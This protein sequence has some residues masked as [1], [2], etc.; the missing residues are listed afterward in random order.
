MKPKFRAS[1][2]ISAAACL[3]PCIAFAQNTGA[4]SATPSANSGGIETVVVT[5][6]KREQK[7]NDVPMSITAAGA[8]E[9]RDRG[10]TNTSDLVKIVPGFTVTQTNSLAPVYTLRGVGLYLYDAGL[11]AAPAVSV[12]SDEVALPSPLMTEAATLDL[13]HVEVLKGPQGTLFGQN[14]TGGAINYVAAKPTD[15][16]MAGADTTVARFGKVEADGFVS[17]PLSDTLDGRLAV[18]TTQGGA[19]QESATR[20]GDMLGNARQFQGRLLLDWHPSDQ[21]KFVLNVTGATDN[22]DTLAGQ[23]YAA[24]P[25]IPAAAPPGL[26]TSPIV[27]HDPQSADWSPGFPDRSHD[28]YFRTTLRGDYELTSDITLTSLTSYQ[29]LHTDRMLDQDGSAAVLLQLEPNGEAKQFDQELRLSGTTQTLNWIV[30][31][32]YGHSDITDNLFYNPYH[33]TGSY[34]FSA[35]P[36]FGFGTPPYTAVLSSAPQTVTTAAV[37]GNLEY[38]ITDHLTAQGGIRYTQSDRK[39]TSCTSDP[40]PGETLS[41][42]V[43]DF[44]IAN[45]LAGIKTSP[46]VPIAPNAC[47]ALTD[48]P[49]YTPVGLQHLKLNENNVSWRTGLTYQTDDGTLIYANASRGYKAGAIIPT[50]GLTVASYLPTKQEKLDAYEAGIKAPLFDGLAQFNAAGFYYDYQ[51]KQVPTTVP[52][53]LFGA[54][55]GLANVPRSRVIGAEAQLAAEPIPGLN[56]NIAATYLDA[57]VTGDFFATVV[58]G[59]V[60]VTFNSKGQELPNTPKFSASADAQYEWTLSPGFDA[61]VGASLTY[62]DKELAQFALNG[63]TVSLPSYALL[64]LRAGIASSDGQWRVL[65]WG[66]NV[67][68]HYYVTTDTSAIDDSYRFAGMPATYGVTISFRTN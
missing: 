4:S 40:L 38:K 62:L 22:S 48:T 34:A 16:F 56:L 52:D 5:A 50:A 25:S 54:L 36:P 44:Q 8:Q 15:T 47:I 28:W 17:G 61:L 18:R 31:A 65:F 35:P 63:T 13:D 42:F 43:N 10:I 30:G 29:D 33:G 49:D 53:P 24:T 20:P 45:I 2:L 58:Q 19:W 64:D 55:P 59:G 7:S 6:Q 14:A 37:F 41:A 67:T 3:T 66:R 1:L 32:N 46:F 12:Y 27:V 21:L 23:F 57:K 51:N 39:A 26:L 9:L 11:G 68:N 60:P